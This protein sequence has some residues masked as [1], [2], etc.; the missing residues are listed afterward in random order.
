LDA[1]ALTLLSEHEEWI[2]QLPKG[3]VLTPHPKEFDRLAG[4]SADMYSRHL[5]QLEFAKK[6]KILVV[7]KG[8][9]TI[10]SSGEGKSYINT[11]GNPGMATGGTGD[12]LTGLVTSMIAQG[13]S[14]LDAT[15][16]GV[17]IHGLAGDIALQTSSVES[18][19]AGDLIDNFGSAFRQVKGQG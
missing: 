13:Y 15:L 19:I 8:A 4:A 2:D 1:D 7:L 14:S 11:S 16:I 9:N 5:K 17:F 12:V 3:S 18:L 10:V 6:H